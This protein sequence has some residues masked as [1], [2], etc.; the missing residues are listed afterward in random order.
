MLTRPPDAAILLCPGGPKVK[1]FIGRTDTTVSARPGGLPDV[2]DSA[3]N[4]A[5][6]F[7]RKGYSQAELAALL[8]AHSTSTQAFVDPAQANKSQDST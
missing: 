1:T 2:F 8:G 7:A 5:A 3:A 6:L 4:L